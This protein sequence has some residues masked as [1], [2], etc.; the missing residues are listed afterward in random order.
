MS[1]YVDEVLDLFIA[2]Y[3]GKEI[4]VNGMYGAQSP[5]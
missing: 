4:D 2:D 1:T 5:T 3:D